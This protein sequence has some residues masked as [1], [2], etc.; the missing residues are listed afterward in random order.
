MSER[1]LEEVIGEVMA[2]GRAGDVEG[3]WALLRPHRAAAEADPQVA[4]AWIVLGKNSPDPGAHRADIEA[5]GQRWFSDPHIANLAASALYAQVDGRAID[6]PVAAPDPAHAAAALARDS[7][8]SLREADDPRYDDPSIGGRLWWTLGNA[9]RVGGSGGH[10]EAERALAE[11]ERL[12]PD[13]LGLQFDHGLLYK[14]MH[15]WDDALARFRRYLDADPTDEAALENA[16]VCAT[17]LG[18]GELAASM[19]NRLGYP[20][21]AIGA[22]GMARVPDQLPV[23]VRLPAAAGF[24]DVPAAP[25][26]PCCARISDPP[27]SST[28]AAAA[29]LV[30]FDRVQIGWVERGDERLPRF[31]F[32]VRLRADET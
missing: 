17:I 20:G 11:A 14:F 13:E 31:P 25:L 28:A 16:A 4:W 30:V 1:D 24:E 23:A 21:V 9:L 7:L 10:A 26:S 27:A 29:D 8:A 6:D 32:L 12:H 2:R 22:D 18:Q 15:R 5:L 19:W 3:A